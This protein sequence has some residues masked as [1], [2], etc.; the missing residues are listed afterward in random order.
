MKVRIKRIDPNLALPKYESSGAVAFDLSARE[1]VEIGPH[2]IGRVPT[3]VVIE[4]QRG[5]C[6]F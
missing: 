1:S 4:I 3:N 2:T 5:L 6:C